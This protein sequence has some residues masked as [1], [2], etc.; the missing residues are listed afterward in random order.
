MELLCERWTLG[1]RWAW[2]PFRP[3]LDFYM[4][5]ERARLVILGVIVMLAGSWLLAAGGATLL[6]F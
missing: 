2:W 4:A 1:S 3:S 5:Y 6:R